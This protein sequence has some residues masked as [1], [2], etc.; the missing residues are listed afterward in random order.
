MEVREFL[1]LG[2]EGNVAP[3]LTR[4]PCLIAKIVFG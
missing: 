2:E 4:G 3:G 1:L